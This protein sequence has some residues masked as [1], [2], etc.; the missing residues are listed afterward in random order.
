M[1][2]PLAPHRRGIIGPARADLQDSDAALDVSRAVRQRQVGAVEPGN[3]GSQ[4]KVAARQLKALHE[5]AGTGN[6]GRVVEV[7]QAA[8]ALT[9]ERALGPLPSD[10]RTPG[11][12][13]VCQ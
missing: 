8:T 10:R 5:V 4:L 11:D 7:G 6:V 12:A 13:S 1:L 9:H 3:T 2:L